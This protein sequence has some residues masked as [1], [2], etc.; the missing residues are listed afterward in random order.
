MNGI[1]HSDALFNSPW[2]E[3]G[4]AFAA[5]NPAEVPDAVPT[6]AHGRKKRR[7]EEADDYADVVSN[8]SST[9]RV[10]RCRDAIQ[11]ILQRRTGG[12][13]RAQSYCTTREAL[14]RC[15]R[16]KGGPDI[17]DDCPLTNLPESI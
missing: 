16:E 8:L 7:S 9:W 6:T 13:W 15:V 11:W 1:L 2:W 5:F 3:T 17:A 4:S 12:R 10:I 14:L